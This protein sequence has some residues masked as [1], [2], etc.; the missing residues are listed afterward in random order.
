MTPEDVFS[1]TTPPLDEDYHTVPWLTIALLLACSVAGRDNNHDN[2]AERK[3]GAEEQ[4]GRQQFRK[5]QFRQQEEI[6]DKE[7][8]EEEDDNKTEQT[9]TARQVCK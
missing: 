8:D 6:H 5:P 7:N 9:L 1:D 2:R 3:K 4:N